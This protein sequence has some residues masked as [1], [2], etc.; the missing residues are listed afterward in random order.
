MTCANRK[1]T[2]SNSDLD[3][4]VTHITKRSDPE[5]KKLKAKRIGKVDI[6][7]LP[8]LIAFVEKTPVLP[9]EDKDAIIDGLADWA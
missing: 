5:L 2:R 4:A 3:Q 7:V 6:K 9:Q 8:R 1:L